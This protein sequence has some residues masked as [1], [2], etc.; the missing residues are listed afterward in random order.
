M[1][2]I[3][4]VTPRHTVIPTEVEDDDVRIVLEPLG[5]QKTPALEQGVTGNAGVDALD[6]G[7]RKPGAQPLL[8]ALHVRLLNAQ[9]VSK[10]AGIAQKEDANLTFPFAPRNFVVFAQPLSI[11]YGAKEWPVVIRTGDVGSETPEKLRIAGEDILG[12]DAV[13]VGGDVGKLPPHH[14]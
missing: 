11:G 7:A 4:L 2:L 6:C 10:G 14:G 1:L 9:A 8:D 3:A 5:F 12:D 13:L